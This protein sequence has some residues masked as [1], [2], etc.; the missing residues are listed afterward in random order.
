MSL[1]LVR[2]LLQAT[3]DISTAL[4]VD[5]TE[6]AVWQ[7]RLTNLAP[8]PTYTGCPGC[9][10]G[11]TV[12]RW[13]SEGR[14]WCGGNTIGIQ[15]IYPGGQIGLSSDPGLLQTANNMIDVM[16]RWSDGNGTDTF[17]PAAAR[18]GYD[19]TTILSQLDSW[20]Q[21][22][23]Y[24][25]LHIHTGG[26]GLENLNTVPATVAEM[27]VQSF[28]GVIRVF[29]NWPSGS[30]AKFAN[31]RAYGGF[32]VAAE[33]SNGMVQYVAI[34]SEQGKTFTLANPWGQAP[35]AVYRSG[36]SVPSVSG[37]TVMVPATCP[38][39]VIV[40]AP[41]GTSYASIVAL[42]NAQ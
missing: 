35:L 28:Q 42:M 3:I 6:R 2:Y 33:K 24:P 25:N 19:P 12:F 30:D 15:H 21:N 1:G 41:M 36:A 9:K 13:T 16:A 22:N 11:E 31:L 27:L 8:F 5:A 40:L 23:T 26:G 17:Y 14:D 7:D 39:D 4:N 10:T 37:S 38:G 34:T 29:P 20:I 18:V 32:L